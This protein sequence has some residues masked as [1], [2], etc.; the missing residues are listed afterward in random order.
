LHTSAPALQFAHHQLQKKNRQK[1]KKDSARGGLQSVVSFNRSW[2]ARMRRENKKMSWTSK[3]FK[4][5]TERH[6]NHQQEKNPRHKET[7]SSE[8]T[9][10]TTT[11]TTTQQTNLYWE[12]LGSNTEM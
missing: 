5:Q 9:T 10:T 11:T 4:T 7:D 2:C 1:P 3:I 8:T 6:K 12:I